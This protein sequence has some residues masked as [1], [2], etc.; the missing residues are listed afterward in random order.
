MPASPAIPDAL[1]RLSDDECLQRL[2]DAVAAHDAG[3]LDELALLL[4]RLAVVIE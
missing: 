4:S 2:G 3:H 1:A